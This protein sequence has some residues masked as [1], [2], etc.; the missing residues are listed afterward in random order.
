MLSGGLQ[1]SGSCTRSVWH[2]SV[3]QCET[4]L[5]AYIDSGTMHMHK[6]LHQT[7]KKLVMLLIL[8]A[9]LIVKI[10]L[11][12]SLDPHWSMWTNSCAKLPH[13]NHRCL[14]N[15]KGCE[16]QEHYCQQCRCLYMSP[17][18]LIF[19][20]N[21]SW[22]DSTYQCQSM[23]TMSQRAEVSLIHLPYQDFFCLLVLVMLEFFLLV[24]II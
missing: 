14:Y 20:Y 8:V 21:M 9:W 15:I 22:L 18:Q 23:F 16:L 2:P 11:R 13:K 1:P 10:R 5:G 24:T 7:N 17:F 12:G 3:G 4:K 6:T 19:F